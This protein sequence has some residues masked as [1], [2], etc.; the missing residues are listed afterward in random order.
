MANIAFIPARS[1]SK[2]LPNK[3][4]L[5]INNLTLIEIAI[6]Q[7]EKIPNINEIYFSSDSEKY[8][9]IA[10][11]SGAISLGIRP[12]KLSDDQS[13]TSDLILFYLEKMLKAD[14]IIL[15]QPTSPVRLT[16]DIK[17]G[18]DLS[19]SRKKTV[20]SISKISEPHPYKMKLINENNVIEN[21][22]KNEKY[23]SEMPRQLL[24]NAYRLNGGFYCINPDIIKK[25]KKILGNGSIGLVTKYYPNIDSEEDFEYLN[26][27]HSMNRLPI[28][29]INLLKPRDA[30]NG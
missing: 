3:N 11:K 4:I 8:N 18:I 29:F 27:L 14:C 16:N 1:K 13:L 20:T 17:E 2:G 19:I 24:P 10:K 25:D 21:F 12:D 6:R 28:E 7:A 5:R 23:N 15:L 9:E 30:K 26:F 22:I